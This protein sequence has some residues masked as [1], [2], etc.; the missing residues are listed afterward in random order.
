MK[1]YCGLLCLALAGAPAL[2][3]AGELW[4]I[5][6]TTSTP[7]GPPLAHSES[8]CLPKDGMEPTRAL[9]GMGNCNFLQKNG[10]AAALSFMLE[11]HLPGMPADL[12]E[13]RVSGDARLAGDHFD[14]RYMIFVGGASGP[15]SGDFAMTG[16]VNARRTGSCHAR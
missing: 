2:A 10:N 8:Q 9:Q 7:G 14:M 15:A 4:Q 12:A 13:F 5:D 16:T 11:C 1:V 6:S 3:G